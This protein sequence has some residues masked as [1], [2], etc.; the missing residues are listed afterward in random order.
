MTL[1]WWPQ[2]FN[3]TCMATVMDLR[4]NVSLSIDIDL[5]GRWGRNHTGSPRIHPSGNRTGWHPPPLFCFCEGYKL[6]IWE[7]LKIISNCLFSLDKDWVCSHDAEFRDNCDLPCLALATPPHPSHEH[8]W[9]GLTSDC[10]N[11]FKASRQQWDGGLFA[12][13]RCLYRVINIGLLL[14]ASQLFARIKLAV[15]CY[16][17]LHSA[18]LCYALIWWGQDCVR[19]GPVT[20]PSLSDQFRDLILFLF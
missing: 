16:T 11:Y 9:P 6:N 20:I 13:I 17:L 3:S 2:H 15:L 7:F 1:R 19:Q 12:L 14:I 5:V 4:W 8:T 10:F 18:T